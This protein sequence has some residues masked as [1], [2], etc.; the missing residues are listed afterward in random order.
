MFAIMRLI[1]FEQKQA[2]HYGC[3][4]SDFPLT[5]RRGISC[6][7]CDLFH[8]IHLF[9]PRIAPFLR[10]T[11]FSAPQSIESPFLPFYNVPQNDWYS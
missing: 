11:L 7:H 6:N 10:F 8:G 1:F 2:A 4:F 3:Y 5:P 9:Q